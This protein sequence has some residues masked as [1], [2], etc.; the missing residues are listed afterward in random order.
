MAS[1]VN[2]TYGWF[3]GL[4]KDRRGYD[5]AGLA[6][7]SDGRIFTGKQALDLKLIDIMGDESAG[8]AWLEK[9]KGVAKDLPVRDWEKP[10]SSQS[11]FF[12]E[13]LAALAD[14]AGVPLLGSLLRTVPAQ[15]GA[16][17]GLVSVWQPQTQK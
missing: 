3:K 5:D 16:L 1:V 4:V 11:Y 14:K 15:P 10:S 8:I 2:D 17:D 7:V 6:A 9:D 13:A 12:A